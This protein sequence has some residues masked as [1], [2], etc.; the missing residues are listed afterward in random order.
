MSAA[1]LTFAVHWTTPADSPIRFATWYFVARRLPI[2]LRSTAGNPSVLL[3]A[4]ERR[5]RRFRTG[6]IRLAEQTF[7]LTVRMASFADVATAL[8]GVAA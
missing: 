2:P 7:G 4:A 8:A 5:S 3:A 1:T 6:E